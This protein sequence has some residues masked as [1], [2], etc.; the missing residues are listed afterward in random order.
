MLSGL[1]GCAPPF[2][3]S[4][5]LA[6]KACTETCGPDVGASCLLYQCGAEWDTFYACME[7]HLEGGECNDKVADCAVS[8]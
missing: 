6:L 1:F 8:F 2:C 7:P 5:G 4:Q 3:A